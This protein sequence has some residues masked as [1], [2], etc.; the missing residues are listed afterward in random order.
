MDFIYL[1]RVLAKRKWIII[2]AAI[3]AAVAAF[4]LT[5]NEPKQYRSSTQIATG[6]SERPFIQVNSENFDPYAAETKFNN[7]IATFTLPP[8]LSLV[9]YKLILH[10]LTA[11]YPYKRLT[12]EEKK[13]PV[14]KSVDIAEAKKVF[15][16]HL[17]SMATLTSFNPRDKKLIEF[18]QLYGYDTKSIEKGLSVF[19][20]ARTDYL[21]VDFLSQNPELSAFVVND[22]FQE[23]M[24][25][26]QGI[27]SQ[28]STESID[29]LRS[30]MEKKRQELDVK[31]ALVNKMGGGSDADVANTNVEVA[32]DLRKSLEDEKSKKNQKDFEI[33]RID[34]KLAAMSTGSDGTPKYSDNGE[35]LAAQK[36][37]NDAYADYLKNP[38]DRSLQERYTRLSNEYNK[39]LADYNSTHQSAPSS[40]S[41]TIGM[42]R[43]ELI[44]KR[45]DLKAEI[46]AINTSIG[47]YQSQINMLEGSA[48][49]ML[50]TG[51]NL[52]TLK[53]DRDL[54]NTDWL[55]AKQRYND[56]LT[57]NNSS[58]NSFKQTVL[59][60]PAI[61]PEP[62]KRNLI[63]GMAGAAAMVT[64]MLIIILLTYL[65]SS[66]KTPLIFSRSVNLKLISLVNFMDLKNK[67][68]EDI[69]A[70]KGAETETK[71]DRNK[72]NAFRESI[73]KL[74]YEIE[75]TGKKI[76]L[77]TSTKKG[78]GKT[79]LIQALS[80][81]MS[82]SKK[83][84]LIIDT[85]FCNPDLTAQLNAEP[86]LEKMRPIKAGS[87]NFAEQ[88]RALS[89][90]IGS[91]TVYAIGSEGGDYTPSEVL[92]RENILQHLHALTSEFDYIFLEGP[93]LNDFSD[94]KELAQYVDGVIAVFSATNIIK[95]IDKQSITF[96]KELNGKFCGSILN[97]VDL[98]NVNVT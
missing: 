48:T 34:A 73:R 94:S 56:A 3:L 40:T 77:F 86:V 85:N 78:Q 22:V 62:S 54:A 24:R 49:E 59:A 97:M 36:A 30:I 46:E 83:K 92:P 61:E 53:K 82:L 45:G 81:S 72:F 1:L 21:Q 63:V 42:S 80:Y 14:Y 47:S 66:I 87:A 58:L 9:S 93:P 12:E 20:V 88:V 26:S 60:Q 57:T 64:T 75:S 67:K 43:D 7:A 17:D 91:G 25:Y 89:K 4:Y 16:D 70:N 65:D 2:G 13:S 27:R 15:Q 38:N 41:S 23:F 28:T 37:S 55:A 79:T 10:D 39:K 69:V 90:D 68:I 33:R 35:L 74:R 5:R 29:T 8:V 84:I 71:V 11:P 51:Q 95:Q 32:G 18:L 6:Y 50:R 31:I 76:F 19:R 44:E 98:K 96:F 52:E